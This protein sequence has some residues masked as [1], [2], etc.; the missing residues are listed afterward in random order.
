MEELWKL[1]IIVKSTK[2]VIFNSSADVLQFCFHT[3]KY[4]QM[5]LRTGVWTYTRQMNQ[6]AAQKNRPGTS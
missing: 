2:V 5:L 3:G 1:N 6:S 4:Q